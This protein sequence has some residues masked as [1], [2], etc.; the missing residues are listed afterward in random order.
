ML[1]IYIEYNEFFIV[2]CE[3][4][5]G[6]DHRIFENVFEWVAWPY[7]KINGLKWRKIELYNWIGMSK[8][9]KK[10]AKVK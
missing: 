2:V 7:L 6:F 9:G 5:E 1:L 10:A 8:A 4:T 3:K